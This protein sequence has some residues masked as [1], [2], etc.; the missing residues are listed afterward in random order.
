MIMTRHAKALNKANE[1]ISL[2]APILSTIKHAI[3]QVKLI[4]MRRVASYSKHA[5]VSNQKL[6]NIKP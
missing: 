6:I 4:N 1:P 2:L 5:N 3:S